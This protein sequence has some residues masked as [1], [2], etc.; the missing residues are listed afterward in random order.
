MPDT[1]VPPRI[2]IVGIR[3]PSLALAPDDPAAFEA[4]VRR[5][6]T[7]EA[8]G[9]DSVWIDSGVLPG[10]VGATD[11]SEASCPAPAGVVPEPYALLGALAVRTGSIRL[12]AFADAPDPREPSMV[13]KA[14]A[15]VDVISHGRMVL[16]FGSGPCEGA[17]AEQLEERLRI[18]RELLS[19]GGGPA[20]FDGRHH[21]I[22]GAPNLPRPVQ[23]GGVPLVVVAGGR[24]VLPTAALHADAVV[25]GGG[26]GE[27]SAASATVREVC[28]SRGRPADAVRLLW[29]GPAPDPGDS[30]RSVATRLADLV[31]AG[32]S[33]WV[34]SSP[35]TATAAAVE[36]TATMLRD[37]LDVN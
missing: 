8:G 35:A 1:S 32:V 23:P 31:E 4:M 34:V 15:A 2:P 27:I 37:A 33:G 24:C 3:L 17:T 20:A 19:P 18:C 16:A 10:E 12:A 5:A 13:A 11:G 21:R 9:F 26:A 36:R 22:N 25:L 7:A 30:Q 14:A 6:E 29:A 28:G